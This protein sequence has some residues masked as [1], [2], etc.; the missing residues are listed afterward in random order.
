MKISSNVE[1]DN[2]N[3]LVI[4]KKLN[5]KFT[6]NRYKTDK[7]YRSIHIDIPD[8]LKEVIILYLKY[9]YL[10][11]ELKK[12]EYDIPFLVDEKGNAM[13]NLD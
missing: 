1:N 9:H 13:K 7:K 2:F 8:P 5:M 4:D 6:L 12:Q 11:N 3:Y 10:K